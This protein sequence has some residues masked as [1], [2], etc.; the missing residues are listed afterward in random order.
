VALVA[1]ERDRQ[2]RVVVVTGSGEAFCSGVDLEELR[3]S[4]GALGD[5][6]ADVLPR[7]LS[8]SSSRA[9]SLAGAMAR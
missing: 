1:A 6:G 7:V 3:R 9:V 4:S 2:M 5:G 8:Q